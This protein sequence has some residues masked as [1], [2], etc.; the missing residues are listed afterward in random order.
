[1]RKS[2]VGIKDKKTRRFFYVPSKI[3]VLASCLKGLL[4][5]L[6]GHFI[7]KGGKTMTHT[8]GEWKIVYAGCTPTSNL[9]ILA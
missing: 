8:K 3:A 1:M 7:L 5:G 6:A 4:T 9:P 2:P